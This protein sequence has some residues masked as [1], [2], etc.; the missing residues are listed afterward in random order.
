MALHELNNL[1]SS[2]LIKLST[3]ISALATS[4]QEIKEDVK[5]LKTEQKELT[6]QANRWKGAI[7]VI[8]ALGSLVSLILNHIGFKV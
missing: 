4:V 7:A 1:D 8:I 3:D 6:K 2:M 5:E